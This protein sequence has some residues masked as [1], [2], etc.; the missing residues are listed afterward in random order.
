MTIPCTLCTPESIQNKLDHF[1]EFV[2]LAPTTES[3]WASSSFI[4]PKKNGYVRWISDICQLNKVMIRKHPLP[5]I[6]DILFKR[7]GYKFLDISMQYYTFKLDE[8]SPELCFIITPFEKYK[9]L[10][11]PM[12]LKCS[13]NMAQSIMES[14]LAGIDDADVYID[15][16]GAFLHTW[17][18]HIK[19]LGNILCHLRE[20]DFTINPLKCEWAINK[21]DWLG[22]WLTPRGLKPWKKK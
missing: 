13:P 2:V 10:R 21:T 16:V 18:D 20:N 8:Y 12:G 9:F 15:N 22:Y 19:L 6:T 11:L 7:S 14:D 17:D 3:E 4:I 5:I 1:V